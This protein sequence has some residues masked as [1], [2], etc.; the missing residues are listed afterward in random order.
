LASGVRT[1]EFSVRWRFR[2]D[3][4]LRRLPFHVERSAIAMTNQ[5]SGEAAWFRPAIGQDRLYL[6]N[7]HPK[8]PALNRLSALDVVFERLALLQQFTE[9]DFFREMMSTHPLI[10]VLDGGLFHSLISYSDRK[11]VVMGSYTNPADLAR[12]GYAPTRTTSIRPLAAGEVDIYRR[13]VP[14]ELAR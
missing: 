6:S 10:G 13:P 4:R 3:K 11:R 14:V 5:V 1:Q 8:L 12:L 7:L 2:F 9:A